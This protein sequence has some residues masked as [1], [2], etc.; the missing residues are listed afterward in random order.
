MEAVRALVEL[1]ASV[2]QA[3]V[4]CWCGVVGVE[5]HTWGQ[6][7]AGSGG[8]SL[9]HWFVLDEQCG[10]DWLQDVGMWAMYVVHGARHGS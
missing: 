6:G 8:G 7:C 1:G 5:S 9:G 10:D 3:K 2:N 4:R